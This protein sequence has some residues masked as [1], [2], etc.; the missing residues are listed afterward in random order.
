LLFRDERKRS[1]IWGYWAEG[2]WTPREWL[3]RGVM[4]GLTDEEMQAQL[5]GILYR[6]TASG[7]VEIESKEDAK[8]RG[9]SSPDRAEAC[10]LPFARIVP[11]KQTLISDERVRISPV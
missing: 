5:A 7:R 8:K 2:Y 10:V 3:E 4:S 1:T 9:Q 6:H 11:R